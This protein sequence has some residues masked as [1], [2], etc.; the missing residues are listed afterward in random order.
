MD[1]QP[2]FSSPNGPV[3]GSDST[4]PSS[5][6]PHDPSISSA[7]VANFIP[8]KLD[9]LPG[10]DTNYKTWREQML[11]L[12]RSQG[13]MHYIDGTTSL[14]LP[15][16]QDYSIWERNN[17]LVKG[18]ILGSISYEIASIVLELES[19]QSVW[20]ILESKF[21]RSLRKT[22]GTENIFP[23]SISIQ[24]KSKMIFR[25]KNISNDP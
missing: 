7:N 5:L 24:E 10:A 12:I 25:C 20:S 17:A 13:L 9:W 8:A 14:P 18:W 23:F 11:C 3:S 1:P 6:C 16:N 22:D 15:P 2:S 21:G 19:A 4:H